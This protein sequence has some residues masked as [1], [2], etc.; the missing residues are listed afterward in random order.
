MYFGG[1]NGF[2]EFLPDDLQE[3]RFDPPIVFTDFQIF[4]KQVPVSDDKS[5][6]LKQSI[7]DT[8]ELVLPYDKSV[9][10]FE[11]NHKCVNVIFDF[12]ILDKYSIPSSVISL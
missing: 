9:I 5:S 2:N 10:S 8:R 1:I 7:A 4:N 11:F 6:I 12:N 3:K